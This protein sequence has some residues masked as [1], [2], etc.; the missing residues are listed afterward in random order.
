MTTIVR[1]VLDEYERGEIS[2]SRTV[3]KLNEWV[4][5]DQEPEYI[6]TIKGGEYECFEIGGE[7]YAKLSKDQ[8]EALRDI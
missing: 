6:A 3:Q 1:D 5:D 2:Y 8:I 7:I 4:F